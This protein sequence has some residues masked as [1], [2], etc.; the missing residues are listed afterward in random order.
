[1]EVVR[2]SMIAI[3]HSVARISFDVMKRLLADEELKLVS[4]SDAEMEQQIELM[5]I[6]KIRKVVEK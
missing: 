4:T 3:G 1:M 6:D 2:S 5:V